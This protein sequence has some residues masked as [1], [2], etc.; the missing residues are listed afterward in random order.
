MR[1]WKAHQRLNVILKPI[2]CCSWGCQICGK[3]VAIRKTYIN[4][5]VGSNPSGCLFWGR[6]IL[7][8]FWF[9]CKHSSER[10]VTRP[11]LWLWRHSVLWY[12]DKNSFST[13]RT[14]AS[15]TYNT[16]IIYSEWNI[17]RTSWNHLF[18]SFRMFQTTGGIPARQ[19]LKY[20]GFELDQQ[21]WNVKNTT[22]EG[23]QRVL[24]SQRALP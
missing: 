10:H 1:G 22:S 13:Q 18:E 20:V 7:R 15:I 2:L 14:G 21:C 11:P 24:V 5:R 17:V 23:N 12:S 8:L 6:K 3:L 4:L 19:G 16:S 9:T